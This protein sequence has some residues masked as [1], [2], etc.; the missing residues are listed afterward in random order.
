MGFFESCPT[1]PAWQAWILA[2]GTSLAALLSS[3]IYHQ[4]KIILFD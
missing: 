2:A 4:V 3:T 1:I